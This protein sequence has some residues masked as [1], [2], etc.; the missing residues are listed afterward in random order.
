MSPIFQTEYCA[1]YQPLPPS[2]RHADLKTGGWI[3]FWQRCA[4]CDEKK[5]LTY[6][7]DRDLEQCTD[8]PLQ[9]SNGENI[10]EVIQGC[11]QTV[12]YDGATLGI[13][14]CAVCGDIM[15]GPTVEKFFV[16]YENWW[17]ITSCAGGTSIPNC[18]Y[19]S[20]KGETITCA[21]CMEGYV[22]SYDLTSCS[23]VVAETGPLTNC[24][25]LVNGAA[26]RCNTCNWEFVFNSTTIMN[27]ETSKFF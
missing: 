4:I 15:S 26:N 19:H 18:K 5:Y 14:Y 2:A 9:Y 8:N 16:D 23:S 21:Y 24:Y 27:T 22:A 13:T 11:L 17:K 7:Q 3:G 10:C 12:C 6:I 1:I 25:Q 20:N